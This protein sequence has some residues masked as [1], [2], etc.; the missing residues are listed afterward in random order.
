MIKLSQRSNTNHIKNNAHFQYNLQIFS[1]FYI[2]I[3]GP[4]IGIEIGVHQKDTSLLKK[5]ENQIVNPL[6]LFFSKF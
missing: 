4:Y 3:S 6:K 1:A 5:N 2:E